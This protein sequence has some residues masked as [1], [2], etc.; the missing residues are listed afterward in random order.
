MRSPKPR[1]VGLRVGDLLR[2]LR[3]PR[4]RGVVCVDPIEESELAQRERG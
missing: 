2:G 3:E 4:E 1:R